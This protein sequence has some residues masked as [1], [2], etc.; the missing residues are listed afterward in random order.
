MSPTQY[1]SVYAPYRVDSGA[2]VNG[3]QNG[4]TSLIG[5]VY[6][7]GHREASVSVTAGRLY[8]LGCATQPSTETLNATYNCSVRYHCTAL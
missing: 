2:A 3:S 8:E 4:I 5:A 1:V 7:W 6:L